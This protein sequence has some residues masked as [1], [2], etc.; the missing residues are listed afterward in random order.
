MDAR[1]FT[2]R[3]V[4]CEEK[5]FRIAY[6][7]LGGYARCEDAVQEALAKAWAGRNALRNPAYFETWLVRVLINECRNLQRR[8]RPAAELPENYAPAEPPDPGLRDALGALG[9]KYRTPL[10]LRYVAGYSV[11]ET[12]KILRV[13]AGVV[14]WR[15]EHAKRELRK[16]LSEGE[17]ST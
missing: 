13:T 5:L 4:A 15:L 14:K 12:A 7:T 6:L 10:L 11:A 9:E 17:G 3:V 16:T 2:D 8:S 1:E